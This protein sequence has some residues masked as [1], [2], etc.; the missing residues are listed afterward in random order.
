MP[1]VR[2]TLAAVLLGALVLPL[3]AEGA[4]TTLATLA[5]TAQASTASEGTT[6]AYVL[7]GGEGLV[8][9]FAPVF[10][11]EHDELPYNKIGTPTADRGEN[12]R[13][14]VFV[15]PLHATIYTQAED[16]E[17]ARGRYTNL[18]YRIHFEANPFTFVPLNVGAGKNV[19]VLAIV[20]LNDQNEPVWL[21]TVQS[22]GCYHAIIPT[23]YLPAGAYPNDWDRDG[24]TVYGEHLPGQLGL[25]VA[26]ASDPRI[27]MTIRG[28]SHRCKGVAVETMAELT[29][30]MAVTPAAAAAAPIEA[31]KSLSLPDGSETSFYHT[32]GR[33]KGLVK[34]AFKPLET[35][36][37]GLWAW[38]HNV[39]QDREYGSKEEAGR[40][41][42]TT[43]F[44]AR[45]KDA[46]LWR[47]AD[48]LIHNGWKP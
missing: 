13:E 48:F 5:G 8:Q 29:G 6:T 34:D 32:K 46:D 12:G 26:A 17:T 28:G 15:D 1:L 20:T 47:F 19:G 2:F 14:R 35:M 18:I 38:D 44:F 40:R 21:T 4:P 25:K 27:V 22:C 3:Q 9:R 42:Y 10:V 7:E 16:F 41:F 33:R 43:L 36:L 31:L 23:D 30:A 37:F 24:F 45:K 39:G 11:I